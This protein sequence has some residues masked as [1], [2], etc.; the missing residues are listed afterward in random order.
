MIHVNGAMGAWPADVQTSV[1]TYKS[2]TKMLARTNV[3]T[4]CA[5]A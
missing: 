1:N 4:V 5:E 2:T 3:M